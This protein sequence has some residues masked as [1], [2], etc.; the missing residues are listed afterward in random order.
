M[1]QRMRGIKVRYN[2]RN[3]YCFDILFLIGIEWKLYKTCDYRTD[4]LNEFD[5][6]DPS[7]IEY[8]KTRVKEMF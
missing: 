6:D 7:L 3:P 4:Y 1:N 8:I 5:L 2:P